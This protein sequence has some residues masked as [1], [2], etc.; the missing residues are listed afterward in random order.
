MTDFDHSW[1]VYG[2][3]FS[4]SCGVG[5]FPDSFAYDGKRVMKWNVRSTP[6]GEQWQGGDVISCCLDLDAGQPPHSRCEAS[7][8]WCRGGLVSQE[9]QHTWYSFLRGALRGTCMPYRTALSCK[10]TARLPV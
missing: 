10:V 4:D 2:S 9:W 5:D 3:R 8:H 6:Y 1:T 7:E